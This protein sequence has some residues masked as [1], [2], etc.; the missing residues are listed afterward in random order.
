MLELLR[1]TVDFEKCRFSAAELREVMKKRYNGYRF[2]KTAER[3]VYNATRCLDFISKLKQDYSAIPDIKIF[4]STNVDY[5]KLS[6][7]LK[8]IN[9]RDRRELLRDLNSHLPVKAHVDIPVRMTAARDTL[10][11]AEGGSLLFNMG[12]LTIMSPEELR[13]LPEGNHLEGTYL[14]IPNDYF[15][16]LFSGIQLENSPDV[17]RSFE[18]I[19][20]LNVMAETNDISVLAAMLNKIAGAFIQTDNSREGETQIGLAVY[21]A[22]NLVT[23][24]RFLLKREYAVMVG[25]RFVFEDGLDEDEYGDPALEEPD[26]ENGPAPVSEEERAE[27]AAD[28]MLQEMFSA[29]AGAKAA[30]L[31]TARWRADLLAIN[32][33]SGPSYIFEF[34]YRRNGSA[35]ETAKVRVVR[36]LYERAVKQLN[37]Y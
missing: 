17:L 31:D 25:G 30:L 35:R 16:M 3:T 13:E 27:A 19:R 24:G 15:E 28:R 7:F 6:G 9:E 33:G 29:G 37:F 8:L 34:K 2:A 23:N 1:K 20:N 5:T 4:S 18:K 32:T 36:T 10:G 11:Y 26:H 14:R 21:M 12:F 22:L